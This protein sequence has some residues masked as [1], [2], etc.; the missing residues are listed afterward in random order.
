MIIGVLVLWYRLH[1]ENV[2]ASSLEAFKAKLD[3]GLRNLVLWKV[4][5]CMAEG[6]EVDG[7]KEAFQPKTLHVL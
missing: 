1:T 7:L 2:D 5:L 6:L 3:I 4:S